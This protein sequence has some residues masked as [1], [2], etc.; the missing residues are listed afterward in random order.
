MAEMEEVAMAGINRVGMEVTALMGIKGM[1]TVK[2][3]ITVTTTTVDSLTP[4]M[5]M[6][7]HRKVVQP[8]RQEIRALQEAG[9][10]LSRRPTNPFLG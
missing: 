8:V 5:E 4:L 6:V 3:I 1:E 9:V 7:P 2:G 10:N